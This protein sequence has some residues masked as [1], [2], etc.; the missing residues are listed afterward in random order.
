VATETPTARATVF[1]LGP[2]AAIRPP[3]VTFY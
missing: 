2:L 3:C 1:R